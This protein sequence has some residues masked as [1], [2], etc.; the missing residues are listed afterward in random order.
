MVKYIAHKE[1]QMTDNNHEPSLIPRGISAGSEQ[2]DLYKLFYRCLPKH[3]K[4][5]PLKTG[6]VW[7]GLDLT[8][9]SKEINVSKQKISAWLKNNAVPGQRVKSLMSLPGSTLTFDAI[10]PYINSR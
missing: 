6:E 10:G 1:N 9:I 7:K 8:K 5:L 3:R 4:E 2:S